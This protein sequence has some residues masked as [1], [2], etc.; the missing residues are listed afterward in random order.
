[1]RWKMDSKLITDCFISDAITV[2]KY[3][4]KSQ[5]FLLA[6]SKSEMQ[7]FCAKT[8]KSLTNPMEFGVLNIVDI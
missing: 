2:F 5:R 8:L 6:T 1:M 7:L 3:L 4:S